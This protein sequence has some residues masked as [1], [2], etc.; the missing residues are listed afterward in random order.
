[1]ATSGMRHEFSLIAV[2]FGTAVVIGVAVSLL[3]GIGRA[4]PGD[5]EGAAQYVKARA[6]EKEDRAK[7]I[8]LYSAIKPESKEWYERAQ[9]QI[10]RLKAEVLRE[11]PK[12][13]P[14]EQK[15]YDAWVEFWRQHAGDFDSLIREGEN[16]VRA[17]PRG[18]LR[19]EVERQIAQ[20]RQGRT[21]QRV[22]EAEETEETVARQV[23]RR[24]FAGA[25]NAIEKVADRL[26]PELDVWPRLAAK[27]DEVVEK[28]RRYYQSQMEEANRMVKEGQKDEA[29]R[30]WYS[31]LRSFGDGRIPELADL[32]RAATLRAEEIPK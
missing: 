5:N 2:V 12:P 30:L 4:T 11:P 8:E 14:Q 25:L 6:A 31:T 27:R 29:R 16:F 32:H 21:T 24:D 7:A 26:R 28:A 19:P 23:E 17:H 22:R 13:S 9:S 10:A 1:M 15:D 3:P 18:E 20:A